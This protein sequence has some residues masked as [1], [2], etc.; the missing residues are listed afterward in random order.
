MEK[1]GNILSSAIST[2]PTT[3]TNIQR[4][5]QPLSEKTERRLLT[6][7]E[8]TFIINNVIKI[9]ER[10]SYAKKEDIEPSVWEA[11]TKLFFYDYDLLGSIKKKE[12]L[13]IT[14]KTGSGKTHLSVALMRERIRKKK[15]NI[16]FDVGYISTTKTK[17]IPAID[18]LLDIKEVFSGNQKVSEREIISRY[19]D[20]EPLYIDDL[21]SEKTTEWTLQTLY[22]IIDERYRSFS[23]TIITS[24]LPLAKLE[25]KLGDRIASRIAEMCEVIELKGKDRRITGE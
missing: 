6:E 9:P 22:A 2:I 16:N 13:Y 19:S 10:Y 20:Y 4:L 14:G 24:N 12:G 11:A 17:W 7:R 15:V 3:P 1:L 18:L 21:G 23:Q 5:E 8:V 25:G